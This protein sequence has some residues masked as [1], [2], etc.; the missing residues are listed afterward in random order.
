MCVYFRV[1]GCF[2]GFGRGIVIVIPYFLNPVNLLGGPAWRR[3]GC[4]D[5]SEQLP[6]SE[7]ATR[8]SE[9]ALHQELE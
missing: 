5:T 8:K 4:V 3:E 7:G 1:L 2:L 9:M 6:V